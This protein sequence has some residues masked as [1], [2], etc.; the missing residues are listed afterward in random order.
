MFIYK[1]TN[2]LNNKIYIGLTTEKSVAERCRKRNA[3]A[4]YRDARSSY[5]L[6]AIRKHGSDI[7]VAETIDTAKSLEELK[8]KEIYY[9]AL[10]NSTNR[11]IGY[12]LTEG[13]EGNKG[14]KMS[15]ATKEKIRLKR[16]GNKWSDER[17]LNHSKTLKSL[18]IDRTAGINN[19]KIHNI[20]TSKTILKLSI[21]GEL[22][23]EYS[24]ISEAKIKNKIDR[25]GLIRYLKSNKAD[26]N[27]G[28]KGFIYRIKK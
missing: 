14:L 6:N 22:I 18:N 15:E 11:N 9:I 12:N 20:K 25:I 23:E 1:L 21:N 3:E 26:L 7:F 28:Y 8:Q 16:L 10:Y 4:K 2:T 17:K 24:S 27:K 19:C 5:I 13:G